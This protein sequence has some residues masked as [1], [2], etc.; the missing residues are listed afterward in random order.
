MSATGNFFRNETNIVPNQSDL[1]RDSPKM[2]F[3]IYL[4]EFLSWRLET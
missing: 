3:K 1:N 2:N 4:L